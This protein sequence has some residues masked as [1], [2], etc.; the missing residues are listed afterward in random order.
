MRPPR[1]FK[2]LNV[3]SMEVGGNGEFTMALDS[4][5]G[6][7]VANDSNTPGAAVPVEIR[8]LGMSRDR[9]QLV[10][11][12]AKVPQLSAVTQ[13]PAA[14]TYTTAAFLASINANRDFEVLGTNA[15]STD[16][17]AS[18]E[19]GITLTAH[20]TTNDSTIILPHLTTGQ[21]AWKKWTWGTD[22]STRWE[23][24]IAT[25]S[26][27]ASVAIWAGLKLSNTP[28][29]ATD[30]D[31]AFFYMTTASSGTKWRTVYSIGGTDTDAATSLSFAASTKYALTIDIDSSR[32]ARYYINGVLYTTSTALTNA[33]D[34]IPYIGIISLTTTTK[35]VTV[36]KEAI[37]RLVGA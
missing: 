32:I 9:I 10:E 18:A 4:A 2:R 5:R 7:M 11:N 16:V 28:T 34:L 26:S 17:A 22:R 12:F 14:D 19:G 15:V 30:D 3:N 13:A 6:V 8:G 36:Y 1:S 35:V 29:V 24:V 23:C 31:Q 20:A 33:V 37:S 27:V 21:S 25:G